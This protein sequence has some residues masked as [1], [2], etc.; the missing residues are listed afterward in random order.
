MTLDMNTK[1]RQRIQSEELKTRRELEVISAYIAKEAFG[2][3]EKMKRITSATLDPP[4]AMPEA[5]RRAGG[6]SWLSKKLFG[7]RLLRNIPRLA[8]T[9][10]GE[11][12]GMKLLA[13]GKEQRTCTIVTGITKLDSLLN[14]SV[15]SP[16]FAETTAGRGEFVLC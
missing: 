14:L 3:L 11:Q 2:I 13:M 6:T 16:A 5:G 1:R 9:A 7:L 15:S 12:T 4:E 10:N 8:G